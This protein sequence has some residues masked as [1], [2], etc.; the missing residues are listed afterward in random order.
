MKSAWKNI[1]QSRRGFLGFVKDL[2]LVGVAG[3]LGAWLA[4]RQRDEH[5]LSIEVLE[6]SNV[7]ASQEIPKAEPLPD[8]QEIESVNETRFDYYPSVR[9]TG[10][11]A[12]TDIVIQFFFN[13]GAGVEMVSPP[14]LFSR[15][16]LLLLESIKIDVANT[17]GNRYTYLI[18]RLNPNEVV[19]FPVSFSAPVQIRVEARSKDTTTHYFESEVS[20]SLV[21]Y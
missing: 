4:G 6:S 12:E 19:Y 16:S 5:H 17:G 14:G 10:A 9:N 11:F 1:K 2:I 3:W 13:L 18:P 7:D 15:V 21:R 20:D 8:E